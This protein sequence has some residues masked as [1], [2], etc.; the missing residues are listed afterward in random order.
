MF[1]LAFLKLTEYQI[2]R[3]Y[4]HRVSSKTK[5]HR[6]NAVLNPNIRFEPVGRLPQPLCYT[7]TSCSCLAGNSAHVNAETLLQV[8]IADEATT[9]ACDSQH[10]V[11]YSFR[12]H[13][14]KIPGILID[15]QH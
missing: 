2:L 7:V 12:K 3:N 4:P 9:I 14:A 13:R 1:P 15:S 6:I 8:L 10:I 5:H 11:H